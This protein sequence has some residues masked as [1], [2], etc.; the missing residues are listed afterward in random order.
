[1]RSL[2]LFVSLFLLV[3]APAPAEDRPAVDKVHGP[4]RR[5]PWNDS[6]VVGSP[7]PPLPYKTV[8]AFPGL[9]VLRPAVLAPEPGSDRLFIISHLNFW[10]GPG[11]LLAVRDAQDA[12]ST[13]VL[14]DIDGLPFGMAFHPDYERNGQIFIGLSRRG[15][16]QVLRYSVRPAAAASR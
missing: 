5:I 6:R 14:L 11:R 2:L 10:A 7:D 3:V 15:S 13:E 1:M 9:T 16:V 4:A 8:R 12:S